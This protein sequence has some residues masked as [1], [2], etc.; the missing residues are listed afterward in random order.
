[1]VA[2]HTEHSQHHTVQGQDEFGDLLLGQPLLRLEPREPEVK[3]L[4]ELERELVRQEQQPG[5]QE[6]G[7]LIHHRKT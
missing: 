2:I 6:L 3:A 7:V 5:E 1:M 4:E